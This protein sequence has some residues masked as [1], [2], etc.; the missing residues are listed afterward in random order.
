M[1]NYLPQYN[2]MRTGAYYNPVPP[3]QPQIQFKIIPVTNKNEADAFI[4]DVS[5]SPLFFF[6]RGTNEIYMKQLD[7]QTGLAVFKEFTEKSVATPV[8]P[9][10]TIE[11][12]ND[13]ID[14]LKDIV[15]Q[16]VPPKKEKAVK[17]ANE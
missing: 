17:N 13:K 14:A 7:L 5:G 16:L 4:P 10:I 12:L 2:Q 11:M 1:Q 3:Q 15:D 9:V 6:N 8:K